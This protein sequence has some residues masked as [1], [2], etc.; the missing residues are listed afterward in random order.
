MTAARSAIRLLTVVLCLALSGGWSAF[1]QSLGDAAR[2]QEERRAREK[3][4]TAASPSP[5][6]VPVYGEQELKKNKGAVEGLQIQ[7]LPPGPRGSDAGSADQEKQREIQWRNRFAESRKA[8][9]E[10]TERVKGLEDKAAAL[11]ANRDLV[12]LMDPNRE[13]NRLAAITALE[14]DVEVA[15]AEIAAAEKALRDLEA[16]ARREN[17]PPGWMR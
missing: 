9:A 15:R 4:A 2:K 12:N 1:A 3:K 13:Q 5:S 8:I 14:K 16:E 11:R 6:P 10:K 17:V 7:G